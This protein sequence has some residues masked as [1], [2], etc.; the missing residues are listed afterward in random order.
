VRSLGEADKLQQGDVLICE[1]TAPPW[2]PLF[3]TAAAVVTDAGG[4]L[5]HCA[6][7]ARETGIPAV[8]GTGAATSLLSDGMPIEVDGNAGTVRTLSE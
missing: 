6:I 1:T 7:L 3:A 4:V 5:S 8:V 2:S